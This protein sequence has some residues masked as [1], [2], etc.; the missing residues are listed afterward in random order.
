LWP[1]TEKDTEW[2]GAAVIKPPLRRND[3]KKQLVMLHR[4]S[5]VEV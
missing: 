2:D 4:S 3:G 5:G 1:P